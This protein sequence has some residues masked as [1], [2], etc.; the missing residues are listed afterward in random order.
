MKRKRI[1]ELLYEFSLH[2]LDV[3]VWIGVPVIADPASPTEYNHIIEGWF[4]HAL[5]AKGATASSVATFIS[6]QDGVSA[7][8]VR[9]TGSKEAVVVYNDWP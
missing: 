5:K 6:E 8:Q 4:K 9:Y 7:V 1:Q 2:G 3:R